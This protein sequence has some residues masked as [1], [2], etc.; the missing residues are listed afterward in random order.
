MA[1]MA[2]RFSAWAQRADAADRAAAASAIARAY[3]HDDLTDAQR[4]ECSVAMAALLDDRHVEVRRALAEA[5]AASCRAPRALVVALA[6]DRSEIA[7]PL[8]ARSPLLT[9]AELVDAVAAGDGV[10]QCALAR[11]PFLGPGPVGALAEVGTRDARLALIN[12]PSAGLGRRTLHSLFERFGDD[13]EVRRALTSRADLPAAL[14]AEIAI[15]DAAGSTRLSGGVA[16]A[17]A[18]RDAALATIAANCPESELSRLVHV[19]R[20]RNALTMA[21]LLRSLAGGDRAFFAAALAG[22]SGLSHARA[23]GFVRDP[24]GAGFAAAALKAGFP[25]H[26][27]PVFRTALAAM[28]GLRPTE[29]Q[30]L[31]ADVVGA[32][33]RF[34]ETSGDPAFAPFLALLWRFAAEAARTDARDSSGM[35][36]APPALPPSLDF[37]PANDDAV[38]NDFLIPVADDG[39]VPLVEL[40]ADLIRA[41]DAVSYDQVAA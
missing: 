39:R 7:A 28:S 24:G 31:K 6:N 1:D 2:P 9:D 4:H 21:L 26:S 15:V 36:V 32:I 14:D 30:G 38:T 37:P 12:N 19:L 17:R 22:L 18:W 41:L 27:L 35:P 8:L 20:L 29:R 10:A 11:R 40:P 34:C 5:F 33:I 16:Q 13:A 23:K 25:K 3:L